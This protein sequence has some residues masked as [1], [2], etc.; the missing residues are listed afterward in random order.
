M[1]VMNKFTSFL[2]IAACTGLVTVGGL[3]LTQSVVSIPF[4][5]RHLE[6]RI[7]TSVDT[8]ARKVMAERFFPTIKYNPNISIDVVEYASSID[9]VGPLYTNVVF[10]PYVKKQPVLVYMHGY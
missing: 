4:T 9:G 3:I 5:G 2:V 1:K 7:D 6:F 10:D 8:F